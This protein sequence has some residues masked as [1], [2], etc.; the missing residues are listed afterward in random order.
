M[1]ITRKHLSRRTV[2]RGV[3]VSIA[4]PLLDAMI[5]ASTALAA[6]A[7]KSR[8]FLGFFYLP[9]G[10]IMENWTPTAAGRD[11]PLSPILKPLE[12]HR[13]HLTVVTGLDNRPAVSSATHAIVPGTWLSCVHP[14][15]GK[16]PDDGT[17]VDQLAARAIGGDTPL[18]SLEVATE[19]KG[20]SAACA[21]SFGCSWGNS[22]AFR[23]PTAPLPMEYVPRKLF[24]R[25]F[26]QGDTA[27]QRQAIARENRSLIDMV[28]AQSADLNRK[29]GAADRAVMDDYLTSVRE[30]ERRIARAETHDSEAAADLPTLPSGIPSFDERL[31]LMFD[32]IAV[33]FQ[34]NITR[35]A[36]FMMAAE[37]SNQAYLHLGI[38]EAFHPLSHHNNSADKMAKLTKLQAYHSAAIAKF[39]D[40]LAAMPNGDGSI[41]DQSLFLYGSNMSNSAAHDHFPLPAVLIGRAGGRLKGNQHLRYPDHTPHANLLL[42]MM[43]RAGVP[44]P[45][46]GDSTGLFS[47][48]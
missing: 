3:G 12:K 21:G 47:E 31:N 39:L 19:G 9:H 2:L 22:I 25:L 17:T 16:G 7:A 5:P 4:L 36:T 41:L 24:T 6:T 48:V 15:Q 1:F 18:P 23:G 11:F 29:I 8:P 46:V 33:S 44:L 10:A 37:V 14:R 26:G 32:M 13:A 27:E 35:V 34:S 28:L 43:E 40:K 45:A 30:I 42:T 38:S 20:G